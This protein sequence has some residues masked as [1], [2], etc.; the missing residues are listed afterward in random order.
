M[1]TTSQSS[2][3]SRYDLDLTQESVLERCSQIISQRQEQC[4]SSQESGGILVQVSRLLKVEDC[5]RAPWSGTPAVLKNIHMVT[6]FI[7][8][9]ILPNRICRVVPMDGLLAEEQGFVM[10]AHRAL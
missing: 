6:F 8:Y 3:S 2:L 1:D 9:T 5:C 4:G 7:R 10:N